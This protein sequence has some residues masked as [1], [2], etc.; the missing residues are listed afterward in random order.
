MFKW[1]WNNETWEINIMTRLMFCPI[2]VPRFFYQCGPK[3]SVLCFELELGGTSSYFKKLGKIEQK[4]AFLMQEKSAL[5]N[6]VWE[7]ISVA[8]WWFRRNQP[9]SADSW[10]WK[11]LIPALIKAQL[12]L[13]ICFQVMYSVE[14]ELKKAP[15]SAHKFWIKIISAECV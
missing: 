6:A 15:V 12:A 2:Y 7:E 11:F 3:I 10:L 5:F 13:F 8:Q 1:N 14:S 9:F 4:V